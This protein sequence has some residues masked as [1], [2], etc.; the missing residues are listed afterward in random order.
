MDQRDSRATGRDEAPPVDRSRTVDA[1]QQSST[2]ETLSGA[3]QRKVTQIRRACSAKDVPALASL[4][5]G[6]DGFV[7]DAVRREACTSFR[8]FCTMPV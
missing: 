1:S 3:Q 7:I 4:A 8:F 6:R 2:A 5:S